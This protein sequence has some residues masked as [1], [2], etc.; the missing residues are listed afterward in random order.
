MTGGADDQRARRIG[1]LAA[2][3]GGEIARGAAARPEADNHQ[4]NEPDRKL[5]VDRGERIILQRL[6]E[7]QDRQRHQVRE[8][9]GLEDA[10]DVTQRGVAPDLT[11]NAAQPHGE[12]SSDAEGDS[13]EEI[14]PGGGAASG[15]IIDDLRG[16][17][18]HRHA[19]EYVIAKAQ[20]LGFDCRPPGGSL[21]F[22]HAL[23]P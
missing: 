23:S 3:D 2:D 15:K 4:E 13:D 21:Y 17:I 20:G 9:D 19:A 5:E 12:S 16:E 7:D 10:D 8:G 1:R 22:T 6:G 11:V 14:E 18:H